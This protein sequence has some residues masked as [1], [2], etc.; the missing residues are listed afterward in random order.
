ME[1]ATG[2]SRTTKTIVNITNIKTK[3]TEQPPTLGELFSLFFHI[4]FLY[5]QMNV[6][7]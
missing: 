1:T 6:L 5:D 3:E 4:L 2:L 7:Y